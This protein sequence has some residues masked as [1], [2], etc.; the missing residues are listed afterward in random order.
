MAG[1]RENVF[2]RVR[3]AVSAEGD[4]I[5]TRAG[6]LGRSVPRESRLWCLDQIEAALIAADNRR[7]E[8]AVCEARALRW[9]I[10][11]IRDPARG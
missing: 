3:V 11:E 10:R 2:G 9:A 6:A 8:D 7:G 5:L 1:L 4:V